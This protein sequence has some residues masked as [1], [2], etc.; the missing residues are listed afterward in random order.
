MLDYDC[1]E[2]LSNVEL[3]NVDKTSLKELNDIVIDK[4]ADIQTKIE[5]FFNQIQNP[6]CFLV[7]GTPVK[8]VF[9]NKKTLKECLC[10][11]FEKIEKIDGSANENI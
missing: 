10:N 7:N 2:A 5:S 6:Y 1:L 11:Y 9:E 3:A 8:L 4:E